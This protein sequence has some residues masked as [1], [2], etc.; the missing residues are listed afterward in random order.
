MKLKT[1]IICAAALALSA[2]G[3]GAD[4]GGDEEK[5]SEINLTIAQADEW[6]MGQCQTRLKKVVERG[7]MTSDLA[8][9]VC[10]CE[11]GVLRKLDDEERIKL[12][13]VEESIAQGDMSALEEEHMPALSTTEAVK[14]A[15]DL[16]RA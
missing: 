7:D 9:S 5:S 1:G 11:V 16:C 13:W 2:C 14:E 10:A 12:A 4:S 15:R 6:L 3:G 8:S